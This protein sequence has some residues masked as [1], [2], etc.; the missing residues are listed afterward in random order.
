MRLIVGLLGIWHLSR[1]HELFDGDYL[2]AR[3]LGEVGHHNIS[4]MMAR[5]ELRVPVASLLDAPTP[6]QR[7]LPC[8]AFSIASACGLPRETVRRKVATLVKRGWLA[9]RDN[10]D[11]YVTALPTEHFAAFNQE[12][13]QRIED[14][15]R[16]MRAAQEKKWSAIGA[17]PISDRRPSGEGAARR[18]A[19][20]T[21]TAGT[22]AVSWPSAPRASAASW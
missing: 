22:R 16:G 17:M 8:N 4:D 6:D 10:G 12:F 14:A 5:G 11:L 20:S 15:A 19:A 13:A 3:I 9:R 7:L 21:P 1:V 18:R 2:L